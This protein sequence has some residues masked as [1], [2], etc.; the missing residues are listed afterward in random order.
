LDRIKQNKEKDTPGVYRR[1]DGGVALKIGLGGA[2][3]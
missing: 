1:E 3:G 2:R